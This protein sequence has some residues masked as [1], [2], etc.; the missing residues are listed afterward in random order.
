[1]PPRPPW[2]V[3]PPGPRPSVRQQALSKDGTNLEVPPQACIQEHFPGYLSALEQG[4]RV[5]PVGRKG[6]WGQA[7]PNPLHK[8]TQHRVNAPSQQIV[9]LSQ[10]CPRVQSA[11]R[12]RQGH[13]QG[14]LWGR[15]GCNRRCGPFPDPSGRGTMGGGKSITGARVS[16][17]PPD[18]GPGSSEQSELKRFFTSSP[19]LAPR[20]I[21][22]Q[23]PRTDLPTTG[24]TGVLIVTA[25][26]TPTP[27]PVRGSTHPTR[28]QRGRKQSWSAPLGT[29]QDGGGKV[30][31]CAWH[32]RS[33]VG[34]HRPYPL[35]QPSPFLFCFYF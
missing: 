12:E 22:S 21:C 14:L 11:C 31:R 20:P 1:M 7:P 26:F 24:R 25:T 18:P 35:F 27:E 19:V 15:I 10:N 17:S 2:A 34:L 28:R 29:Q 16:R 30:V 9:L 5:H 4:C 6:R 23:R 32:P 13:C 33:Q 3:P 8:R